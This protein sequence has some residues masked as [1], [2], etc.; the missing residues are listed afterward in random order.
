MRWGSRSRFP[1]HTRV[2]KRF[3]EGAPAIH[4]SHFLSNSH[5]D[6]IRFIYSS[7]KNVSVHLEKGRSI[8]RT[9][10]L[11]GRVMRIGR[12]THTPSKVKGLMLHPRE[13][14]CM[15]QSADSTAHRVTSSSRSLY[16]YLGN[17]TPARSV[18]ATVGSVAHYRVPRGC[19][20]S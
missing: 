1:S 7:V 2:R 5:L 10:Q 3:R 9:Q 14:L 19:G 15:F 18:Y 4:L 6:L 12:P 13:T 8:P 11:T 16:L 17:S 20:T